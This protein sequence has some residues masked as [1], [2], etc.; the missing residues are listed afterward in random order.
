MIIFFSDNDD[1][2]E[3]IA[4]IKFVDEI[5]EELECAEPNGHV[6]TCLQGIYCFIPMVILG[7]LV[8]YCDHDER[9]A[10]NIVITCCEK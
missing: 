7:C 4:F 2:I 10:Q 1:G 8:D 6:V 3:G 5:N 9:S